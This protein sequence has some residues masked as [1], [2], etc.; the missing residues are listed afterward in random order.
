MKKLFTLSVLLALGG[1]FAA[2]QQSC[3][4]TTSSVIG[5]YEYIATEL[6]FASVVIT[7]PGT[8]TTTGTQPYSNTQIGN[9]LSA[10]NAGTGFSSANV[11]YFDGAGNVS[12]SSSTATFTASTVVGT[13]VVNSDCTINV[14]LTDVFNTTANGAGTV[15]TQAKGS[16]IGVVLG[17]GTE[18]ILS[19]PQSSTSTNGN[20]P[21][22]AGQFA[23]RVSIQLIRTYGYGCTAASLSG[24]YGL[25]GTG[26]LELNPPSTGTTTGT[27]T[28]GTTSSAS[29]Q[30]ISFIG[31]VT[32]DGA[33]NVIQQTVAS[34]S[35]LGSFQF[36][37]TY[38]VNLNC[39]GT[40][41]LSPATST[42]TGTGTGTGT[43]TTTT[44]TTTATPWT[45]N[46]VLTPPITYPTTN[47]FSATPSGNASRPGLEFTF[48]NSTETVFGFGIA[49]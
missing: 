32:F 46:F 22:G 4:A 35:P 12:V 48:Q 18:I 43:T 1:T 6:P 26:F 33:G 23:T 34:G 40:L 2:A 30:P 24:S 7:P 29:V 16:L 27:G 13:Y 10:L 36:K 3:T 49:Q 44:T 25:I 45:V 41:T 9:L 11:L 20:M 17:G 42:T 5:S 15:A 8:T 21:L 47:A 28:T 19:E 14:T 38:T 39:S 31:V 37:G